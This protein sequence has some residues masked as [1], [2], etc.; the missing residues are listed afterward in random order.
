MIIDIIRRTHRVPVHRSAKNH[1]NEHVARQCDSALMS[2][3]WKLSDGL[4]KELAL[5]PIVKALELSGNILSAA[6]SVIGDRRFGRSNGCGCVG[7]W[8]LQV[9]LLQ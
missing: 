1:R 5:L 9:T 7:P 6:R 8:W 3:G 4:L 2:V